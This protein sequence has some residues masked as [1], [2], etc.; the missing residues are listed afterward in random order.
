MAVG[1]SDEERKFTNY[2]KVIIEVPLILYL[3]VIQYGFVFVLCSE[4][5]V[6][7]VAVGLSPMLDAA[8]VV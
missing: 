5:G 6:G 4:T 1:R 3:E 2:R 7:Q 8:I